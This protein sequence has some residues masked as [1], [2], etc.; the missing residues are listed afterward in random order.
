MG[1]VISDKYKTSPLFKGGLKIPVKV[2]ISWSNEQSMT[3]FKEMVKSVNYPCDMDYVDD[4]KIY[5]KEFAWGEHG[6]R[7]RRSRSMRDIRI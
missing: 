7:R 4:P 6:G 3:I 1:K 2:F 5:L